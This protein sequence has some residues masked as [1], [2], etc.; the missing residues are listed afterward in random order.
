VVDVIFCAT[1]A[2][3]KAAMKTLGSLPSTPAVAISVRVSGV[4]L[5]L[6]VL[7]VRTRSRQG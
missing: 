2:A 3:S 5:A 7:P 4:M 6:A 1:T